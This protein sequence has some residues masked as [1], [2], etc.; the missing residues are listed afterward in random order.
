MRFPTILLGGFIALSGLWV[1]IFWLVEWEE[2][3]TK[4]AQQSQIHL[5]SE[6]T[7]EASRSKQDTEDRDK[8]FLGDY[9]EWGFGMWV[10]GCQVGRFGQRW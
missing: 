8:E 3:H 7:P 4:E 6:S 10:L 9:G 2:S 5:H 1:F